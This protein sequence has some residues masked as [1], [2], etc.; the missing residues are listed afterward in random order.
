MNKPLWTIRI[1]FLLLCEKIQPARD[2]LIDLLL[3]LW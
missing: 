2:G 1:F 3:F